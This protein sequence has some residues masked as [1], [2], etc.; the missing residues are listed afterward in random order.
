MIDVQ[1]AVAKVNK[2][3]MPE[4][5]DTVEMVERP[6]GGLS[7]VLVDGQSHGKG[8]KR[9]SNTVA[10]KAIA[11]LGEGIR[12]G[13]A[14][15]AAHDYLY[16]QRQGKVSAELQII[17]VDLA[18][19]TLV[20]SRN[21]HCPVFIVENGELREL[22]DPCEAIGIH[23]RTRPAITEMPISVPLTIIAFSDGFLSA[24]QFSGRQFE[25]RALVK[26]LCTQQLHAS[27]IADQLL[28][29]A[30]QM[31]MGRPDDDISLMVMATRDRPEEEQVRR[32]SVSFPVAG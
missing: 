5:G 27:A 10:R 22:T 17:S 1:T 2:W 9:I 16:T 24:G 32:V 4:S 12:D 28:T 13:A 23:I 29:A 7:F 20:I 14:A 8:A 25:S 11:L 21:T 6:H 19:R 26:S 31:D 30:V 18:T 15:R 3:A